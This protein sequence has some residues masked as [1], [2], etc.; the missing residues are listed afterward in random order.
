LVNKGIRISG[1]KEKKRINFAG[2]FFPLLIV[3]FIIFLLIYPSDALNAAYKGLDLW[4]R[5]VFPSLF[6]FFVATDLLNRTFIIKKAG[7]MLEPLMRPAFNIPGPGSFAFILGISSGYPVGA[8]ITASL[9][10]DGL[11]TNAEGDR[12]LSFSN[13]SGPVFIAGAVGTGIFHMPQAG[14]VLL[15]CHILAG[16]T[17]GLIFRFYKKGSDVSKSNKYMN[18]PVNVNTD[19]GFDMVLSFASAIKNSILTVLVIGGYI[20]FFSVVLKM[21][22]NSGIIKQTALL[23]SFLCKQF[24]AGLPADLFEGMLGGIFEIT[25]GIGMIAKS[26]APLLARFTAAGMIAG[27]GGF[28]VHSQ[29]MGIISG[30]GL[31][32]KPYLTGK[33]IHGLIAGILTALAFWL[34]F[35]LQGIEYT[36][37]YSSQQT[38]VMATWLDVFFSSALIALVIICMGIIME[39][40]YIF[41]KRINRSI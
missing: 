24:G 33:A 27:W 28:S 4:F 41:R 5:I 6:P 22:I 18:I 16:I 12:L 2:V 1:H 35:P 37:V 20:I 39:S 21:L 8:K 9:R 36:A 13:N 25:N 14:L 11:L 3:F 34:V 30:T 38:A 19:T 40:Y 7:V 10:K 15:G 23:L 26:E 29:V 17:V 31:K 32:L